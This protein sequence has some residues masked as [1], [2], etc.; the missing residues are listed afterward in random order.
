MLQ[1]Q[2]QYNKL[3]A[4]PSDNNI[5]ERAK[6]T[7]NTGMALVSTANS[8]LDGTGTTVTLLTG[9]SNGTLL[10]NLTI[11]SIDETT[12]GM[13][14]LFMYNGANYY[15]LDEIRIPPTKKSGTW[16]AFEIS[17]ELNFSIEAGYS[18][19][20]STEKAESFALTVEALDWAY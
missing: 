19:K 12:E 2:K 7:A 14:R 17:F 9:A 8:N 15:L 5:N 3:L 6:Y 20:A 18:I 4:Q 11:K 16:P 13:I 1:F 10:K